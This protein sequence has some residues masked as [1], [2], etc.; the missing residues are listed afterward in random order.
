MASTE[1]LTQIYDLATAAKSD[2]ES[3][4]AGAGKPVQVVLHWSA[5]HYNTVFGDYHINI[6]GD[7][8]LHITTNDFSEKKNHNYYKN[9]AAIGVSLCCG[10]DI[11]TNNKGTEP[12][13]RAQVES[14]SQVIAVLSQSL[15]IPI[16]K[17]HFPTHGESADNEDYEVYFPESTGYPNNTYGPKSD[18]ERWDLEVLYMDES[19]KFDPYDEDNRGGNVLRGK[20]L[21]YKSQ[22]YGD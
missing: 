22:Y 16:D 11:T 6:T 19:T 13:T 12:P 4:A 10:V 3:M 20:G 17:E 14:M 15:D 2:L 9:T 7:G 18:C 8:R 1:E 5:G 21:W